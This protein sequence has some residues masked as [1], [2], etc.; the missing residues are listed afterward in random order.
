MKLFEELPEKLHQTNPHLVP[1]FPGSVAKLLGPKA[2]FAKRGRVSLFIAY[3]NGE[4]AGR[5]AAIVNRAHNEFYQDRVGFFGFFDF[6]NDVEVASLLLKTA[7]DELK[8]QGL[9]SARGPYNPSIN[10]ECG[11]L[12]EGF[13]SPPMVMMPF[14]PDYYQA[15][16]EKLGLQSV[17]NLYA[18]YLSADVQVPEKINRVVE[19]VKKRSGIV[20][21]NLRLKELNEELKIIQEL[22]NSTLKRNWGF[23]PVGYEELQ[24]ASADLKQIV[25]PE[26]VMIAEKEGTAIGFSML[27]PN[28]NEFMLKARKHRGLMRVLSFV[29]SLKTK[30]T[31]EARLAVLGVKPEFENLGI[32]AVFYFESIQ[33]GRKKLI[34]GELSWIEESNLPMMR[35]LEL[36]GASRYKTYRIYEKTL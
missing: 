5:I 24:F 20:F 8:K 32:P 29:W 15:I 1:P 16:Y 27:L 6:I 31:K 18:Y 28:I 13:N 25:Q 3:K 30:S 22:Y 7:E 9:H 35:S 10:D 12:V 23:V 19:R 14:N 34:G 4:P 2:P 17:R 36:M 11:L 26:F 33:R 21:R